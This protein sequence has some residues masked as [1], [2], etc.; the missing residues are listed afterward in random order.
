MCLHHTKCP[1]LQHMVHV[2][3]MAGSIKVGEFNHRSVRPGNSAD[4]YAEL[5][6]SSPTV[7]MTVASTHCILWKG[8]RV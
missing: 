2:G 1:P 6:V 8:G 5:V 3:Q 7:T 4:S